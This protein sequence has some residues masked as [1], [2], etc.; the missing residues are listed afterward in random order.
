MN[1][2]PYLQGEEHFFCIAIEGLMMPNTSEMAQFCWTKDYTHCEYYK[3]CL[4]GESFDSSSD[5]RYYQINRSKIST[6]NVK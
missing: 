5:N 2:C 6:S 4:R 1:R 3:M